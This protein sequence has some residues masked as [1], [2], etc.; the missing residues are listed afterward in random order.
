MLFNFGHSGKIGAAM[1]LVAMEHEFQ[2]ITGK[3]FSK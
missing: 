2:V 3:L 1:T